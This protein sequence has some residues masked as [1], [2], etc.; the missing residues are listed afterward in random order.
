[1]KNDIFLQ[2]QTLSAMCAI[3]T[4]LYDTIEDATLPNQLRKA[5]LKNLLEHIEELRRVME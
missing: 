5:Q 2:Q 3:A 1:M 4:A